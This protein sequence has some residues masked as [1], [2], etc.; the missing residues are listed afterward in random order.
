ME[1]LSP[2]LRR[3]VNEQCGS[4]AKTLADVMV[5]RVVELRSRTANFPSVLE[6]MQNHRAPPSPESTSSS[7]GALRNAGSTLLSSSKPRTV[8][9][10]SRPTSSIF[11]CERPF[12]EVDGCPGTGDA[13]EA[14]ILLRATSKAKPAA[15]MKAKD[16]SLYRAAIADYEGQLSG[17]LAESGQSELFHTKIRREQTNVNLAALDDPDRVLVKA[18]HVPRYQA[19]AMLCRE[20]LKRDVHAEESVVKR[21]PWV[22][23]PAMEHPDL[24]VCAEATDE[25][26]LRMERRKAQR[27]A[28][29]D[30]ARERREAE[31]RPKVRERRRAETAVLTKA[32]QSLDTERTRGATTP[33]ELAARQPMRATPEVRQHETGAG[34]DVWNEHLRHM[35]RLDRLED[36]TVACCVVFD[37]SH[38]MP[39][40]SH[41]TSS[42]RHDKEIFTLVQ[43]WET[44]KQ[45]AD[46]SVLR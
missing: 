1:S 15:V 42:R 45:I 8:C 27:A 37:P 13:R 35:V 44:L 14:A 4:E 20:S 5:Q 26:L 38:D 22:V 46:I 19:V 16:H 41:S 25:D 39:K 12:D 11:F 40:G 32:S 31:E 7:R 10:D 36:G 18:G 30:H 33:G 23:W 28:K 3:L 2:R 24:L 6:V 17:Y 29:A 21:H 34:H 43:E 9:K